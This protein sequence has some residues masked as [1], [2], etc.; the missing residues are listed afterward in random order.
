MRARSRCMRT[1]TAECR[2]NAPWITS[3]RPRLASQPSA[4]HLLRAFPLCLPVRSF[5]HLHRLGR[6]QHRRAH[7][8]RL[9]TA[10]CRSNAPET[11]PARLSLA[12]KPSSYPHPILIPRQ[13]RCRDPSYTTFTPCQPILCTGEC[14]E[15]C[16]VL[17]GG[18]GVAAGRPRASRLAALGRRRRARCAQGA[19]PENGA[20]FGEFLAFGLALR[21]LHARIV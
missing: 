17:R 8:V 1:P 2:P 10:R 12:E 13:P 21:A 4:D 3:A 14:G 15:R 16:G 7:G 18:A 6:R 20:R 11:A 9:R 5:R 19:W